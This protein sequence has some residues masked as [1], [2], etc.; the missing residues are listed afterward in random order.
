VEVKQALL[1]EEKQKGDMVAAVS[2]RRQRPTR[3]RGSRAGVP[4]PRRQVMAPAP[5]IV[6]PTV[7]RGGPSTQRRST[8]PIGG[9]NVARGGK[10]REQGSSGGVWVDVPQSNPKCVCG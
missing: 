9:Q 10:G 6:N 8:A 4:K 2:R 7:T 1:K 3:K 5:V